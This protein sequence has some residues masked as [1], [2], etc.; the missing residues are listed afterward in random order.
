M[1]YTLYSLLYTSDTTIN[2]SSLITTVAYYVTYSIY[3]TSTDLNVIKEKDRSRIPDSYIGDFRVTILVVRH[4]I[5][6][7]W[8]VGC[9]VLAVF[10]IHRGWRGLKRPII[11]LESQSD[12]HIITNRNRKS[13]KERLNRNTR[14]ALADR[15]FL[16]SQNQR[17]T[18]ELL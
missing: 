4:N 17:R 9:C 15:D 11:N 2:V 18:T 1:T 13:T 6:T 14:E 7:F 5:T 10:R 16:S 12:S 8:V 3:F